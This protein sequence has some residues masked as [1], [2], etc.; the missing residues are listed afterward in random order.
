MCRENFHKMLK[1]NDLR[2]FF[3]SFLGCRLGFPRFFCLGLL[4]LSAALAGCGT[5]ERDGDRGAA[6]GD[7]QAAPVPQPRPLPQACAEAP[8]YFNSMSRLLRMGR[9]CGVD[10]TEIR[11]IV[12]RDTVV[13]RFVM[14]D[15]VEAA[16]D[17]SDLHRR[18]FPVGW[19]DATVLRLPIRKVVALSSTHIGYLVRLG[20]ADRIVAVG[21]GDYVADS[22][23]Y[24]R[25]ASGAVAEAGNGPSISLEKVVALEPDLVM[26]FATGGSNDDYER[27]GALGLPLMLTSEWQESDP[28]AKAEWINL[29]VKLFDLDDRSKSG[30]SL[31]GDIRVGYLME[32]FEIMQFLGRMGDVKVSPDTL[33]ASRKKAAKAPGA[34]RCV[35]VLAGMA[36]GGVWHAPGADSYTA[37][38]IRD[39]GGCYL[40]DSEAGSELR[41]PLEK[42][43]AVAD[44][45]DVW[46]NPGMFSSPKEMLAAEPRIKKIRAFRNRKVFQNDARRGP[47]GGNDFFESAPT[48]PVELL[49]NM[50]RCFYPDIPAPKNINSVDTTYKWYRNIYNF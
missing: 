44:S 41:L 43:L 13:K 39:A 21:E 35:R 37:R 28:V 7:A 5:G 45:A 48:R 26:T 46:V 38:L 3:C 22:A 29:F 33:P 23:L 15:S 9:L 47:G 30:L 49:W 12:G 50:A 1:I 40:W 16:G 10:V 31:F 17:G 2:A 18:R 42:V 4:V 27:L 36:Y 34:K 14:L 32:T 11:A 24:A 19:T 6:E 25:V 20:A 8:E